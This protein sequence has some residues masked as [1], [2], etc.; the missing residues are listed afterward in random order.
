[1]RSIQGLGCEL[2]HTVCHQEHHTNI[3]QGPNI[4]PNWIICRARIRI[5]RDM[6]NITLMIKSAKRKPNVQRDGYVDQV[7]L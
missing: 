1:M 3:R 5:Q 6:G 2:G 7:K 4:L